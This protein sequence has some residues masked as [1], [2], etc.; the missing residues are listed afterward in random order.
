MR[1]AARRIVVFSSAA[2]RNLIVPSGP[3]EF[4]RPVGC[5]QNSSLRDGPL[6]DGGAQRCLL[7]E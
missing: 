1:Y 7:K 6:I 3:A 2:S 4:Y 5:R